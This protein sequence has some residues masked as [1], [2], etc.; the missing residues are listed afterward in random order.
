MWK[1]V[2]FQDNPFNN[3]ICQIDGSELTRLIVLV[4]LGHLHGDAFLQP[5]LPHQKK[6]ARALFISIMWTIWGMLE[7]LSKS[8]VFYDTTFAHPFHMY[9][10]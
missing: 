1:E 4:R 8:L 5:L 10:S 3:S 7:L 2:L 6:G 9:F